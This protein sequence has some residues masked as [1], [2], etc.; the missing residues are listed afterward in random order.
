MVRSRVSLPAVLMCAVV[1]VMLFGSIAAAQ[2]GPEMYGIVGRFGMGTP[3]P[4]RVLAMG[5]QVSCVNDNQFANPAFA[6][7]QQESSV[8]LRVTTTDFANG[9]DLTSEMVH[10]TLP[11]RPNRQGMQISFM[12]LGSSSNFMMMPVPAGPV[13]MRMTESALVVDFGQRLT[14]RLTAGLSVL[15]YENVSMNITSA[16]L[17][18]VLADIHDKAS[19]GF[20]GGLAYEL[21][22]GDFAGV[23]YNYSR[24]EVTTSGVAVL[25]G[26]N[27]DSSEL[28]LGVSRHLTPQ[29]LL[30]AEWQHG[31]LEATGFKS[32]ANT[33][34]FGAEYQ[35]TPAWALRAGFS[36]SNFHCGFGWSG[37]NW[38]AE[39]AHISNWNDSDVK[40]LFGGSDTHSF[41]VMYR[42]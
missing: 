21:A 38:R 29:L 27:F 5:G 10:F 24:D 12:N 13:N 39:Y 22:P 17:P 3:V 42:W 33:W 14:H 30:A 32:S 19:Y 36:D 28:V 40:Q 11:I 18:V 1:A 20:R 34:L 23:L 9:P 4:A 15:G 25:P 16:M 8:G 26:T 37:E 6:A 41:E 35:A 7:V 31:A 2:F